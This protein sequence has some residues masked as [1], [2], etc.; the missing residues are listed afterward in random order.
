MTPEEIKAKSSEL[1]AFYTAKA[2]GKILQYDTKAVGWVDSG[3]TSGPDMQ[4]DLTRWRVK[5][6]PRRMWT[7]IDATTFNESQSAIWKKAGA[8]TV[9]EW[10]EV[11]P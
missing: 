7:T 10:Q 3:S 9:T 2:N 1:A 6:E 5:P 11:L 4:S 8:Y